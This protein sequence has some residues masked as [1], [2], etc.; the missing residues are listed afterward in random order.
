MIF[1]RTAHSIYDI[2]AR[3]DNIASNKEPDQDVLVIV[4][5][6][7]AL[8]ESTPTIPTDLYD[9]NRDRLNALWQERRRH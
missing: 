5:D 8:V 4:S 9:K 1:T 3:S 2:E 7:N 6:Y